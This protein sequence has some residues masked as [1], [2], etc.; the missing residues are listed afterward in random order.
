LLP[1]FQEQIFFKKRYY[2]PGGTDNRGLTRNYYLTG[3]MRSLKYSILRLNNQFHEKD[4][5]GDFVT[6]TRTR[7]AHAILKTKTVLNVKGIAL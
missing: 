1:D 5:T 7:A 4:Q 2:V 3:V 6:E